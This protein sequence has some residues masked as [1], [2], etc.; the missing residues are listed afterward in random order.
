MATDMRIGA[1][2]SP[3]PETRP[4]VDGPMWWFIVL[5]LCAVV[6]ACGF[7]GAKSGVGGIFYQ[8]GQG[9]VMMGLMAAA[10]HMVLKRTRVGSRPWL[11]F[12]LLYA[13]WLAA[14]VVAVEHERQQALLA[15]DG[16]GE[17]FDAIIKGVT[18]SGPVDTAALT[19][20]STAQGDM[21]AVEMMMKGLLK[22]GIDLRQEYE[23]ELSKVGIDRLLD[24]PRIKQDKSMAE[25]RAI[26]T[27]VRRVVTNYRQRNL[28]IF[29]EMSEKLATVPINDVLKRDLNAGV[30]STMQANRAAAV[31]LWDQEQQ[32]AEMLGQIA[33]MLGSS[34]ARWQMQGD[35]FLFSKQSDLEEFRQRMTALQK[36][37]AM[38]Q[39]E[40]E[41]R[42][43]QAR[44]RL[45]TLK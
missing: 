17:A 40:M 44:G 29:E 27:D 6:L 35:K 1:S 22:R 26:A 3:A 25:T 7:S 9:L 43:R 16:M 42:L 33:E 14:S 23:A 21:A 15:R 34:R 10:L 37:Q 2:P 19:R 28:A 12:F 18:A 38:Q 31:R 20:Q 32:L 41:S 8:A 36:L 45:D 30:Q 13:A 24:G 39:A 4:Q 11:G 5:S